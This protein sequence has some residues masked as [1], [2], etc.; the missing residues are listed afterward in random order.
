MG[1]Y[2]IDMLSLEKRNELV[3]FVTEHT[4]SNFYRGLYG[5][6]DSSD[7]FSVSS[8]GEWRN[9]PTF[10]KDD[11]IPIQMSEMSFL[12]LKEIDHVRASSGT[13]GKPPLFSPRTEVRGVDYRL[14]YHD[15]K[16]PIL[17]FGVPLMPH[18][19]EELQRNQG[20][21]A[22][23]VTFDPQNPEICAHLA[24]VIGVDAISFFV[25]HMKIAGEALK[26]YNHTSEIRFIELAGGICSRGLY[27][28]IRETFRNAVIVPFYG[29]S[30]TEDVPIGVPCHPMD[31]SDPLSVYHPKDTHYLELIHPETGE[32]VE[33]VPGAEGDLLITSYPGWPCAVPLIRFR[34]GDRVSILDSKCSHTDFAFTVLGRTD[35][36]ILKIQG[37]VIRADEIARVLRLFSDLVTDDFE[38]HSYEKKSG[39]LIDTNIEIHV[40]PKRIPF[41][42]NQFARSLESS[43]RVGPEKSYAD[44]VSVGTYRSISCKKIGPNDGTKKRKRIVLHTI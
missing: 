31:G 9:L 2:H 15:F 4:K 28:Y 12:P 38:L 34:I 42:F 1:Y 32:W 36:D 23:T 44:G 20:S 14:K 30:E 6:Q 19:H 43:I 3:A 7:T 25:H 26:K 22:T 39:H 8:E 24:S 11:L 29:S 40:D 13:S 41:D 33:P 16:N 27:E 10:T 17:S 37:G 5:L 18:W 21:R 35:L